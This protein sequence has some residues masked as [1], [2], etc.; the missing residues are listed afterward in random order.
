MSWSDRLIQPVEAP[1]GNR[2]VTLEDAA[3]Y[4]Q[5]L[6]KAERDKPLIADSMRIIMDVAEGRAPDLLAQSAVAHII[7]GPVTLLNRGK[8][9]RPWMKKKFAT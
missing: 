4:F 3:I 6:P 1:G 9:D 7:H 8:P 2:I 5:K